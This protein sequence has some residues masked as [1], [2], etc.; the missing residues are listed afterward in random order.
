ML[1]SGSL[2]E[3][4]LGPICSSP[5]SELGGRSPVHTGPGQHLWRCVCWW[6]GPWLTIIRTFHSTCI[7][8]V[9][10]APGRS[11]ATACHLSWSVTC[12]A[13]N[14][15]ADHDADSGGVWPGYHCFSLQTPTCLTSGHV[16]AV[17]AVWPHL[18]TFMYPH[19]FWLQLVYVTPGDS[20]YIL[21]LSSEMF[22][23]MSGAQLWPRT[24]EASRSL[25]GSYLKCR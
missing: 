18:V 16:C 21:S 2:E 6:V 3:C 15:A 10:F 24:F 13:S 7:K 9:L 17:S 8:P 5:D 25:S 19:G 4:E 20:W 14:W 23:V 22:S 12:H 11:L 1:P